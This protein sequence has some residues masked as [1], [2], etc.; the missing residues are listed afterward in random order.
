MAV[1]V[2]AQ[3]VWGMAKNFASDRPRA[4]IAIAAAI[5][6]LIIPSV[7]SQ[8]GIIVGAGIIGWLLFRGTPDSKTVPISISFNKK[9]ASILLILFFGC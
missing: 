7:F 1:A 4:T 6:T 2:V 8:V 9:I 5:L 3:A